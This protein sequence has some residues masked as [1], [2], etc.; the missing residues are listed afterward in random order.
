[1][2]N[3]I[4]LFRPVEAIIDDYSRQR[5]SI[6]EAENAVD[7]MNA[8]TSIT[9]AFRTGGGRHGN[10]TP[11]TDLKQ[12]TWREIIEKSNC[13][14]F[15]SDKAQSELTRQLWEKPE[16]LPDL[17]VEGL[18]SWLDG[19]M[20]NTPSMIQAACREV[21]ELLTPQERG[22]DS[23]KT[24]EKCRELPRTGK[25]ILTWKCDC[26]KWVTHPRLSTHGKQAVRTLDRVFSMLDGKPTPD[27][28]HDSVTA[29]DGATKREEVAA[30][31]EYFDFRMHK[32]GNL[33]VTLSRS[34]L[35]EKLTLLAAG[36]TLHKA[37][38]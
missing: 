13:K 8:E 26:D 38:A 16:T 7:R 28:P 18:N 9:L 31:T 19:L 21:F 23:Y 20:A 10:M 36:K 22:F 12:Q 14:R 27:Y 4:A 3:Q 1:M 24:N 34:D 15:M 30:T 2:S 5:A 32:N 33:H 11:E 17:S 29:C 25:V 37:V 6:R 35:V